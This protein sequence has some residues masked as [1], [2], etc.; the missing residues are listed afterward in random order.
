M[1]A[2]IDNL[3]QFDELIQIFRIFLSILLGSFIG[4]E[5]EKY[6][7]PA[8]LRTHM[9]V[10]V[11]ASLAMILS[12]FAFESGDPARLA[13][14]VITGIG[15]IGA[16]AIIRG[17]GNIIGITTAATIFVCAIIGL[18]SGAGNYF[19]AIITTILA[20]VILSCFTKVE[21]R[22]SS[23]RKYNTHLSVVVKQEKDTIDR[24]KEFLNHSH[25][26]LD[27]IEYKSSILEGERVYKITV[28]FEKKTKVNNLNEFLAGFD[29][30]FQPLQCKITNNSYTSKRHLRD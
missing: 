25:V 14:Q 23:G 27:S 26:N 7:R 13:A 15:F 17:E 8:G 4:F 29:K 3:L 18:A 21:S 12:L 6:G 9:L 16:G 1:N 19:A 24:L 5:R 28:A 22:L 2:W 11:S 10:S 30:E 20:L